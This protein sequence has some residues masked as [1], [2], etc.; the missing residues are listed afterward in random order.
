MPIS[1][2]PIID[3]LIA[4]VLWGFLA[5]CVRHDIIARRKAEREAKQMNDLA[6]IRRDNAAFWAVMRGQVRTLN[7]G[8]DQAIVDADTLLLDITRVQMAQDAR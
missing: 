7:A 5:A 6:T 3:L 4:L 1:T 2:D 8:I